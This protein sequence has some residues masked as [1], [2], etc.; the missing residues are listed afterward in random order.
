MIVPLLRKSRKTLIVMALA[1]GL[2]ESSCAFG[3]AE[4]VVPSVSEH[5]NQ[6]MYVAGRY[7][8][9]ACMWTTNGVITHRTMLPLYPGTGQS[10]A[11]AIAVVHKSVTIFGYCQAAG[12]YYPVL[13]INGELNVLSNTGNANDTF[14]SDIV[15]RD[16]AVYI[17]MTINDTA[18][19][20][21]NGI[22]I[23]LPKPA[24]VSYSR[25]AC[26]AVENGHVIVG[27]AV[28]NGQFHACVWIDGEC[29]ILDNT[30]FT[31]TDV[32]SVGW[33]QGHWFAAGL[34]GSATNASLWIDGA[35][36]KLDSS[37]SG[38]VLGMHV[39]NGLHYMCGS[40]NNIARLWAG[41][42]MQILTPV[43]PS[44]ANDVLVYES[45]TY[46][47]RIIVAGR[48]DDGGTMA[49]MLWIN[50]T[51]LQLDKAGISYATDAR[52]V[53]FGPKLW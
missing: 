51:G 24:G 35:Y 16:G 5:D 48:A 12:L 19:V 6:V 9:Q 11:M 3:D 34:A 45:P 22:I 15:E 50:G 44:D 30:A 1:L 39:Y 43:S 20:W 7:N 2:L 13:W 47:K 17:A 38:Y 26:I 10:W 25:G 53:A 42:Y 27:G 31:T 49:A 28:D 29:I 41:N 32:Y 36:V 23:P 14:K 52:A 4:D 8:Q 46:G 40:V 37:G 21:K 18:S 33:N